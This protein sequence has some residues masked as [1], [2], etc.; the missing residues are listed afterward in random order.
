[1]QEDLEIY[2]LAS[3]SA[4]LHREAILA[5]ADRMYVTKTARKRKSVATSPPSPRKKR[6]V[7]VNREE[8]SNTIV[9]LEDKNSSSKKPRVPRLAKNAQS[10]LT[11]SLMPIRSSRL[12][13]APTAQKRTASQAFP[14]E[15]DTAPAK[16][17]FALGLGHVPEE[18]GMS[19]VGATNADAMKHGKVRSKVKHSSDIENLLR[20]D[21][22]DS[23]DLFDNDESM[24][25]AFF[26]A[27]KSLAAET[28]TSTTSLYGPH[29]KKQASEKAITPSHNKPHTSPLSPMKPFLRPFVPLASTTD[30]SASGSIVSPLH[31]SPT[32]F[33]IAEALRYISAALFAGTTTIKALNL[34]VYGYL[35]DSA[36]DA[37]I[38]SIMLADIFFPGKPPYLNAT[39]KVST[40]T[41][42]QK[43]NSSASLCIESLRG[44][45][46]RTVVQVTPSPSLANP[47]GVLPSSSP[48]DRLAGKCTVTVLKVE[49]T[50]WNEIR[51]VKAIL[52]EHSSVESM[53]PLKKTSHAREKTSAVTGQ[54]D[55]YP[56][57]VSP[58]LTVP[59]MDTIPA[60]GPPC[61]DR[62]HQHRAPAT[63]CLL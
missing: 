23:D 36:E 55:R 29:S 53:S 26:E 1:M 32:C 11:D 47:M 19:V 8:A 27:E 14:F 33:R 59:S 51:R 20:F 39:A 25:E 12:N 18:N 13:T 44:T 45:L 49:Q 2:E 50:D 56:K 37:G 38:M 6:A 5:S 52:D 57:S 62:A 3:A 16:R 15:M 9:P 60:A 30:T 28:T 61:N 21:L 24:I 22:E 41:L 54:A 17:Q 34:E 31:R 10:Q 7:T 4:S 35:H 43:G 63:V 46:V 58:L 42:S 48:Q 40:I